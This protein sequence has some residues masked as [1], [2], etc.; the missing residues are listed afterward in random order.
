MKFFCHCN[1]AGME[2][3]LFFIDLRPYQFC[4]TFAPVK[5]GGCENPLYEIKENKKHFL[6]TDCLIVSVTVRN[7][8]T[9]DVLHLFSEYYNST[10]KLAPFNPFPFLHWTANFTWSFRYLCGTWTW[11]RIFRRSFKIYFTT[12]NETQTRINQRLPIY[13]YAST[14]K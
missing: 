9:G 10:I 4:W 13:L 8:C 2:N 6:I 11:L 7:L 3:V 12:R 5:E 14:V 1:C